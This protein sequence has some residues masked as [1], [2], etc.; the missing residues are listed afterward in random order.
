MTAMLASQQ[1]YDCDALQFQNLDASKIGSQ[2]W[3]LVEQ[4]SLYGGD[5]NLTDDRE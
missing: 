3:P 4:K 5:R 1:V 2:S